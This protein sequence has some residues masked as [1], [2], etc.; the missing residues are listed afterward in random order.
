MKNQESKVWSYDY[1]DL[2]F[3]FI[4]QMW[5]FTTSTCYLKQQICG[6]FSCAFG[7]GGFSLMLLRIWDSLP[8][9]RVHTMDSIFFIRLQIHNRSIAL[10]SGL[11]VG[12]VIFLYIYGKLKVAIIEEIPA[13]AASSPWL[14]QTSY[15]VFVASLIMGEDEKDQNTSH[16]AA[17]TRYAGIKQS[18][19]MC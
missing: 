5:A 19:L 3:T 12:R 10:Q 2:F 17:N 8:L 13:S 1:L 16:P 15:I 14:P 18:P 4:F 11:S 7:R 6:S 9:G